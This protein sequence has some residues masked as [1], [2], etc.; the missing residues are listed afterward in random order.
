MR[1]HLLGV[2]LLLALSIPSR[3]HAQLPAAPPYPEPDERYKADILLVVGHPDDDA[4]IAGYLARAVFDQHKSVAA[5]VCTSGDGGGNEV[6]YE[7][8]A[9]LG[10]VRIQEAKQAL[11]SLG[12]N[13]VWF[14]GN[15]DTPGQNPLWSLDRWGHGHTLE[16]VVRLVR[17]TRPEVILTLL[18]DQVAGENHVLL[19]V[20]PVCER[21]LAS[22]CTSSRRNLEIAEAE[23]FTPHCHC[24]WTGDVAGVTAIKH[25]VERWP[26]N[27]PMGVGESG[28]CD[29]EPPGSE[30]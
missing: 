26:G 21:P 22:A 12:I 3:S 9:A 15:H 1:N 14:L 25:W 23:W 27:P 13:N 2:L 29:A 10:Q 16:E 24:G 30:S 8:G 18:P 17:I 28:L 4:L 5:I 7:A 11:A 6:A 19:F 20:C